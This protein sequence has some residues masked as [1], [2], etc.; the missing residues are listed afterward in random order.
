VESVLIG[1]NITSSE[2]ERE[3]RIRSVTT[4]NVQKTMFAGLATVL[5]VDATKL[6]HF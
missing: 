6:T 3:L 5:Q 2:A 1:I 4:V